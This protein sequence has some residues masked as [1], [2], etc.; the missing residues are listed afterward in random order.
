MK[1]G[2]WAVVFISLALATDMAWSGPIYETVAKVPSDLRTQL[3]PQSRTVQK[4]T[5]IA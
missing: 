5:S 1:R 2:A 4:F 3:G